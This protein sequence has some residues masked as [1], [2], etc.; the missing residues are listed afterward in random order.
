MMGTYTKED[1]V[2]VLGAAREMATVG[3]LDDDATKAL[4]QAETQL[5]IYSLQTEKARQTFDS[6]HHFL[7]TPEQSAA[8]NRMFPTIKKTDIW[9]IKTKYGKVTLETIK[10]FA[11]SQWPPEMR[12]PNAEVYPLLADA[13]DEIYSVNGK[14]SKVFDAM[15]AEHNR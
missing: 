4:K 9:L 10:Q 7:F 3:T 13:I 14:D 1:C 15:R 2:R 12:A 6:Q 8:F 5:Q 11:I